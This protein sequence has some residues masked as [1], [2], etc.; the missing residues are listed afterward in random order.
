MWTLYSTKAHTICGF[1]CSHPYI[2]LDFCMRQQNALH[3]RKLTELALGST[4]LAH[5]RTVAC[6]RS[7]V[8]D[9]RTPMGSASESEIISLASCAQGR[10]EGRNAL[11]SLTDL[12]PNPQLELC[13]GPH[14][15]SRTPLGIVSSQRCPWNP[16]RR[17]RH[18]GIRA[19]IFAGARTHF[20][21]VGVSII[22]LDLVLSIGTYKNER[23]S[24]NEFSDKLLR[25]SQPYAC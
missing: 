6:S 1:A 9:D 18:C 12:Y 2:G 14:H 17:P 3:A 15:P 16:H 8:T 19:D 20:K 22:C 5:F 21:F 7:V 11:S 25:S 23:Y 10:K 13:S 24:F 4:P